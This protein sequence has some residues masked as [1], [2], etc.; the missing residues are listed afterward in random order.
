MSSSMF[1]VDVSFGVS[2]STNGEFIKN[3]LKFVFLSFDVLFLCMV[4]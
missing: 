4:V 1:G 3:F 2:F